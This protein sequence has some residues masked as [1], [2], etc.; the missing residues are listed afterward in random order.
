MFL[1][2]VKILF[3][4]LSILLPS[5][6]SCNFKFKPEDKICRDFWIWYCAA[7]IDKRIDGIA[8][9]IPN[10]INN[11]KS[12]IFGM[13]LALIGKVKGMPDYFI[14]KHD[15]VVALE[16]KSAKGRMSD[17]QKAIQLWFKEERIPYY[18]VRSVEE[19]I[20]AL[21]IEGFVKNPNGK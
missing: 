1:I 13:K 2:C 16:F 17:S 15:K 20:E 3:N 14:I 4:I 19:A 18:V 7:K 11:N 21:S 8:T 10:E 9:H 12:P 5:Y 6:K